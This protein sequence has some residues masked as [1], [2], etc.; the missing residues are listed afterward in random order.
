M[1][2]KS[3][4]LHIKWLKTLSIKEIEKPEDIF[5]ITPSLNSYKHISLYNEERSFSYSTKV[6]NSVTSHQDNESVTYSDSISGI[7]HSGNGIKIED[8]TVTIKDSTNQTYSVCA[9]L[10][11]TDKFLPQKWEIKLPETIKPGKI[12]LTIISTDMNGNKTCNDIKH[13]SNK[14]P[15][16]LKYALKNSTKPFI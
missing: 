13:I 7:T 14:K 4:F 9:K 8:V 6:K 10:T 2:G 15:G 12:E 3:G 5:E 1:P 16:T 11:D